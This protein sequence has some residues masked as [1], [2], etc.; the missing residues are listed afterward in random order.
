[1]DGS[2]RANLGQASFG[3][4]IHGAD[5]QWHVGFVGSYGVAGNLFAELLAIVYG[6]KRL[7]TKDS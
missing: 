5:G 1:M 6:L 4:V 7:G 2:L 3:G